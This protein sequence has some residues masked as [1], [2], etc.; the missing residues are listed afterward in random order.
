MR[1]PDGGCLYRVR[2]PYEVQTS[3]FEGPFDLLLHLILREQVDLYEI[4]LARIVDAYLVELDKLD[5]FDLEIATEFLLDRGHAR[6]AEGQAAAARRRRHRPRRRAGPVGGAR[7][8]A[9]PPARVQDVQGRGHGARGVG[10]RRVAVLPP[11]RRARGS[12][13]RPDARPARG[14][15]TGATCAPRTS[16]RCT[17][18][19]CRW[20][21]SATSAAMR[22][23]VTEAVEELVDELPRVGRITF[24]ELTDVPRRSARGRRALPGRARA[25]QAG[26]DRP[27]P[28]QL[29]RRHRDPVDGDAEL[30]GAD[31]AAIDVY[32][33]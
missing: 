21:R 3:V 19:R 16:G 18:S 14:Q 25:V 17:P 27:R 1:A 26:P 29:V 22:V 24:R 10:R 31:L 7:S 4:S 28:G 33:G 32:E 23:S 13:P 2:M 12:L 9:R 20:S 6:R 15:S 11:H 8:A 30:A 5:E